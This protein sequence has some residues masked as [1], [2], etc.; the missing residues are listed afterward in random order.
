MAGTA[1]EKLAAAEAAKAEEASAEETPVVEEV[2]AETPPA[3][4]PAVNKDPAEGISY[5]VQ[6]FRITKDIINPETKE[7]VRVIGF[8]Q[9]DVI[10][11]DG[12]SGFTHDELLA[13][14]RDKYL[15]VKE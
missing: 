13:L 15:K 14:Y 4:E 3:E 2:A 12:K 11:D 6:N 9:K 8:N 7:L 1:K 5:I 10:V